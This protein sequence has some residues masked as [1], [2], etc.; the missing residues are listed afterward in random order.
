MSANNSEETDQAIAI[1]GAGGIGRAFALLFASAGFAVRLCESEASKRKQAP[2]KIATSVRD[3][4]DAGLCTVDV[5]EV[6]A[7][8]SVSDDLGA[9][10]DGVDYVQECVSEDLAIKQKLF[11]ELESLSPGTAILASSSSAITATQIAGGLDSAQ[12]CL[13]AHPGNPPF[14]I[15]VVE[16]VPA[17]FTDG[18]VMERACRILQSAGLAPVALKKEVA[19]FVFNRLQGALLREAYC[20]VR[21]GVAEVDDIDRIV[22][23]GLGLRWAVVGPFE[24]ADLNRPGGIAAHAEIMGAAYESMGAERGQHDPWTPDLIAKVDAQCRDRLPLARWEERVR[25]RDREIMKLLA[26]RRS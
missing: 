13:V 4:A 12:R 21:D 20:L 11:R 17:P 25:W 15:R 7:R 19:G 10:V 23:D 6:V 26:C 5:D 16:L 14:L 9:T 1:V 2:R 3:L 8:I 24:T 18:Q 22:R